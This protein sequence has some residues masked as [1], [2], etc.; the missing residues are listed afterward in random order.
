MNERNGRTWWIVG[1]VAAFAVGA[2]SWVQSIGY[3]MQRGAGAAE[4][5][6]LFID[7]DG[8]SVT[9]ALLGTVFLAIGALCAV[10]AA[11]GSRRTT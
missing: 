7:H 11:R 1:A 5:A 6:F 10:M 3:W 8:P 9:G 4:P 2:L